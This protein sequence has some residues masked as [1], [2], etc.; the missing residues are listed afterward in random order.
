M[1]KNK[2]RTT[3]REMIFCNTHK[4]QR[5]NQYPKINKKNR[6]IYKKKNN[7][8]ERTGKNL[9]RYFTE[10]KSEQPI[11]DAQSNK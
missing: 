8:L 6:I 10:R 9:N 11:T 1:K 3:H 7:S 4:R 5:I 2:R